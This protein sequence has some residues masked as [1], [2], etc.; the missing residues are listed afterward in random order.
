MY[1]IQLILPCRT[2]ASR[3]LKIKKLLCLVFSN[4]LIYNNALLDNIYSYV[5]HSQAAQSSQK[6]PA[7]KQ[8]VVQQTPFPSGPQYIDGVMVSQP[9]TQ[10]VKG[11]FS[12]ARRLRLNETQRSLYDEI[13]VRLPPK[14]L[15]AEDKT[16]GVVAKCTCRSDCCTILINGRNKNRLFPE[17]LAH[18]LFHAIHYHS[19][20]WPAEKANGIA[21]VFIAFGK[22]VGWSERQIKEVS[23]NFNGDPEE[24]RTVFG[25]VYENGMLMFDPLNESSVAVQLGRQVLGYKAPLQPDVLRDLENAQH[26]L[27]HRLP[28]TP[29]R[30]ALHF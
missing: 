7:P 5:V 27:P 20:A 15:V 12:L 2:M 26:R 14:V 8:Q 29:K 24:L 18:E 13:Q 9:M 28:P 22:R 17:I 10:Y 16:M 23:E 4:C 30:S 21:D 19:G 3:L 25:V 1:I 6:N 11:F